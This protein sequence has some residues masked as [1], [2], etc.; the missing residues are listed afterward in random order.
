MP[1]SA[2]PWRE[3]ASLTQE[4]G[5]GDR[6]VVADGTLAEVVEM[7]RNLTDTKRSGMIIALPDRGV[8]PFRYE[9]A[10]FDGLLRASRS[11]RVQAD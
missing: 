11:R 1:A 5:P 3:S 4:D 7:V 10:Q 9:S 8:A 6:S 2:V